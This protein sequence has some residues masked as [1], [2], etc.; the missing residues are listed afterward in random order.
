MLNHEQI[1]E[2]IHVVLENIAQ[3]E[4]LAGTKEGSTTLIAVTKTHSAEAL[5]LMHTLGIKDIGENYIQEAISKFE[6]LNWVELSPVRRHFIGHLQSNKAKQAVKYFDV[7]QSVD[8][9]KLLETVDKHA[10]SE[11]KKIEVM[12]Q[13]NISNESQKS[14][15]SPN[16]VESVIKSKN[17]LKNVNLTGIMTIGSIDGQ[18]NDFF[19]MKE[20]FDRL[21][22]LENN[23]IIIKYISM[24]MSHDYME[25][26]KFGA[27]HVRIGTSILGT[28]NKK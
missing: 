26:I 22:N 11:G 21:Q 1:K 14:G 15:L 13:V 24:G 9:L 19:L 16:E 17:E 27:T 25:A 6:E 23:G 5:A 18:K 28:R 7:L 10:E 2:N 3:A 12:L 20:L 4:R 8:S